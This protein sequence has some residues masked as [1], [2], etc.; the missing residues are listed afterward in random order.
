MTEDVRATLSQAGD[1]LLHGYAGIAQNSSKGSECNFIMQWNGN[2]EPLGINWDEGEHDFPSAELLYNQT[3]PKLGPT[4]SPKLRAAGD[5]S[6]YDDTAHQ[7]FP[8]IGEFLVATL[9]IFEDKF[10]GL[11][12]IG[13]G[14]RDSSSLRVASRKGRTNNN[15][16]AI[17]RIW[18][19]KDL[20]IAGGH[21][22]RVHTVILQRKRP[23]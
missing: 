3:S 4:L 15:V 18:F 11:S 6:R 21:I 10:N 13:K 16:T 7:D 14:L 23:F 19:K 2:G 22:G 17:L 20:K 12:D 9:H 1:Q 8:W 5:S